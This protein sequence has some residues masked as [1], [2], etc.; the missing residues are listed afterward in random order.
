VCVYVFVCVSVWCVFVCVCDLFVYECGVCVC[1][2]CV[3]VCVC[4]VYVGV[5]FN[6]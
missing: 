5:F 4:G 2:V 3:F 1:G 6:K